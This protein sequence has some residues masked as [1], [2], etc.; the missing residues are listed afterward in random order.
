VAESHHGWQSDAHTLG[1][2]VT[3]NACGRRTNVNARTSMP[4]AALH[5][6][7]SPWVSGSC[8]RTRSTA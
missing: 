6:G 8:V 1:G 3:G 7:A 5:L 2:A 4:I